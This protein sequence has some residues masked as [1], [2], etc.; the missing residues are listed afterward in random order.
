MQLIQSPSLSRDSRLQQI[1]RYRLRFTAHSTLAPTPIEVTADTNYL[2]FLNGVEIGRG[3]GRHLAETLPVCRHDIGAALRDGENTLC[4]LVRHLSIDTFS[5]LRGEPVFG[6]S[7]VVGGID[8]STGNGRWTTSLEKGFHEFSPRVNMHLGPL[9]NQCPPPG[10]VLAWTMPNASE[11]TEWTSARPV[12]GDHRK[13]ET[14]LVP[15]LQRTTLALTKGVHVLGRFDALPERRGPLF[16]VPASNVSGMLSEMVL[17]SPDIN[18]ECDVAIGIR[19]LGAILETQPG[20]GV[21]TFPYGRHTAEGMLS[22]RGA[23]LRRGVRLLTC[24]VE[25]VLIGTDR[26]ERY[27]ILAKKIGERPME[28][29]FDHFRPLRCDAPELQELN[30]ISPAIP[31][32]EVGSDCLYA[33]DSLCGLKLA[34]KPKPYEMGMSIRHQG[35]ILDLGRFYY[36]HYRIEF[37]SDEAVQVEIGYGHELSSEGLP[38]VF[39]W[40]RVR[41]P[42]GKNAFHNLFVPRGARYL[43]LSC[44]GQCRVESLVVEEVLAPWPEREQLGVFTCNDAKWNHI[45][46]AGRETLRYSRLDAVSSDSFREF[47]AWLGDTHW[48][49]RNYFY[50]FFSPQPLRQTWELY[51]KSVDAEGR[52]PSVVPGYA[53]F[54]LPV[55]TWQFWMG[56]WEYY[57]YTGDRE[58][59]E[60]VFPACLKT[61]RYYQS[62]KTKQGTLLNP[63]EWRIVDWAKIDLDGESFVLNAIY[64]RAVVNLSQI[65]AALGRKEKKGFDL[66]VEQLQ[67]ALSHPRFDDPEKRLFVDG[68]TGQQRNKTFSQHAQILAYDLGLWNER[69]KGDLIERIFGA[70]MSANLWTLGEPSY[71]WAADILKTHPRFSVFGNFVRDL[72]HH[73]IASGAT[74]LGHRHPG[75]NSGDFREPTKSPCH[76]WSASPVYLSGSIALGVTPTQPG[77][78]TIRVA[79]RPLYAGMTQASGHVPTPLG[80]VHVAWQLPTAQNRTGFIEVK[81]PA[82]ITGQLDL[83]APEWQPF[84]RATAGAEGALYS[85]DATRFRLELISPARRSSSTRGQREKILTSRP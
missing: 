77:Y 28:N 83:R 41:L 19:G 34:G 24:D 71:H 47:C 76:G 42:G 15:S 18:E 30:P 80:S 66:E 14:S 2:L 37:T 27:T 32:E 38:Q 62:F 58:F 35:I 39:T 46:Q 21:K 60:S 49:G 57:L 44:R 9:E 85:L 72:Y 73:K 64:R 23:D 20:S 75:M 31:L 13:L 68:M 69:E 6:L 7:G 74:C 55:W 22:C 56:V 12:A 61:H 25:H 8:I 1:V 52:M 33:W 70:S 81:L 63:P 79:P 11:D 53:F 65:A 67:E 51:A 45:W 5:Y 78:Q 29:A 17:S 16:V 48:I 10:G 43:F 40:D 82:G 4:A 84:L 54:N 3:P 26:P 36:G 50:S 59:L